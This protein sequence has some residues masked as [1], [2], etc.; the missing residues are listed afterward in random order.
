MP[1]THLFQQC[2]TC[3]NFSD[4]QKTHNLGIRTETRLAFEEVYRSIQRI[5]QGIVPFRALTRNAM[6]LYNIKR[7]SPRENAP[8]Q[9]QYINTILQHLELFGLMYNAELKNMVRIMVHLNPPN[10]GEVLPINGAAGPIYDIQEQAAGPIYDVQEQA[11]GPIYDVQEQ[12]AGP[13]YDIQEEVAFIISCI[14][15]NNDSTRK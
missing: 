5:E 12:A 3:Q 8:R 2:R 11:A 15:G 13:I 14:M 9:K 4:L 6:E 7:T 1:I 10:V